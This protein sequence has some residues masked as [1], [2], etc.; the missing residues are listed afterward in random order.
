V[1]SSDCDDLTAVVKPVHAFRSSRTSE[2]CSTPL[3][4]V[5]K[6]ICGLNSDYS[7]G[8]TQL[9]ADS[10]NKPE[11]AVQCLGTKP[12]SILTVI[13]S[14]PDPVHTHLGL[15]FDREI[16]AIQAAA[17]QV[18]YIPH[19]HYLPWSTAESEEASGETGHS[20]GSADSSNPGILVFTRSASL[21]EYLIVL[22]IPELPTSGIDPDMFFKAKGIAD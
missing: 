17:S 3:P 10:V 13:A 14:V 18:S 22:V 9:T 19:S 7:S 5:W 1:A 21:N 8:R 15:W 12:P 16:E 2:P 6:Q 20:E 4:P 11:F